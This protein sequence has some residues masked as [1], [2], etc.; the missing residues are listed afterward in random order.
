VILGADTPLDE[1]AHA[2]RHARC[3]GIVLSGSVDPTPG[4]LDALRALVA[5]A[6]V[7]VLV[8]GQAAVRRDARS[9][10]PAPCRSALTCTPCS[11]GSAAA[12]DGALTPGRPSLR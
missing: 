4:V 8:G 1:V 10:R 5:A 9:A 6:A 2:Q 7:P 12:G 3:D 11:A